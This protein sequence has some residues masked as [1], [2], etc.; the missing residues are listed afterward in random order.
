MKE[1]KGR[2]RE[3]AAPPGPA[4]VEELAKELHVLLEVDWREPASLDLAA[5]PKLAALLKLT[6]GRGAMKQLRLELLDRVKE[7]AQEEAKTPLPLGRSEADAWILMF[8]LES[9]WFDVALAD[10]RGHARQKWQT[11]FGRPVKTTN[12]YRMNV[13]PRLRKELAARLIAVHGREGAEATQRRSTPKPPMPVQPSP[14]PVRKHVP[15]PGQ[16]IVILTAAQ[17]MRHGPRSGLVKLVRE[18]EPYWRARNKMIYAPEGTYK[19]LWRAGLLHNYADF[20]ALPAGF[21]G[22]LVHA[23]EIVVAAAEAEP[24]IPTHVVY[25]IDPH[26]DSSLYPATAAIKRECLLTHTPFLTTAEGAARWFRLEWARRA[27][28]AEDPCARELLLKRPVGGFPQGTGLEDR[29]GTIAL[30]A[31]DRHKPTM[32]DFA[33]GNAELIEAYFPERWATRVTGHLLNGGSIFDDEYELDIRFDVTG[34]RREELMNAIEDRTFEWEK[35]RRESP[36]CGPGRRNFVRLLTRGRE[37]GV[38][39]LARKVLGDECDTVLFFQDA[40]TPREHDMEIQVLDR[41]AQ[42]A[43][44]GTLLLYDVHSASRW[45]ENVRHALGEE[46]N[47]STTS[48]TEAYRRV[49]DVELVLAHKDP[50]D[51]QPRSGRKSSEN[52]RETWHRITLTAATH[53]AG[54]LRTA[55]DRRLAHGEPVRLGFPWGAVVRDV[56]G[57]L[58]EEGGRHALAGALRLQEFVA[59]RTASQLYEA[60]TLARSKAEWPLEPSRQQPFTEDQLR[61]VPT[62]GVI[63][64]RERSLESHALVAQAVAILGGEPVPYPESA[65]AFVSGT[66]D[67]P[68]AGAPKGDWAELDVLLLAA[69]PLLERPEKNATALATALPAD[70]AAHYEGSLAAVS[71]IYLA[72]ESDGIRQVLHDYYQQVGIGLGEIQA[73][74]ARGADVILVNGAERSEERRLA[75]WA[76]LRAGIASTFVTDEAFAWDVLK[77]EVAGL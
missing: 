6:P 2:L 71:T 70:L 43:R 14:W 37:G 55:A 51:E 12:S 38:V 50:E 29:K 61:I 1:V 54:A 73:L 45:A 33:E 35:E 47:T 16:E 9:D 24:K 23:T 46:S 42:L 21:F 3:L 40:E 26:D 60:R 53:L 20:I 74:K 63:G 49:F 57:D 5:I 13:E 75:A 48:L 17:A 41:A 34:Q 18:F 27:I 56:L 62:V 22:G 72:R 67:D 58:T 25:L 65:F 64:A 39:Q 76:A 32:M 7:K 19:E 15:A 68:L 59:G 36:E 10:R 11:R 30:A 31:H 8:A 4:E 66:R 52:T 28:D 69:A 77:E 44:E